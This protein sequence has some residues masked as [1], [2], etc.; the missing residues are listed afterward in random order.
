M[1]TRFTQSSSNINNGAVFAAPLKHPNAMK[2]LNISQIMKRVREYAF[3]EDK[4]FFCT[5]YDS[6]TNSIELTP[7]GKCTIAGLDMNFIM[8]L[9]FGHT[10]HI[11]AFKN[12]QIIVIE[13]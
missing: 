9:A 13:L 2:K 8:T 12:C 6:T 4:Q 11:R 10:W 3:D 5:E 7:V 1:L